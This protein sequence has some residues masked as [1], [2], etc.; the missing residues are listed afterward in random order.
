MPAIGGVALG[1]LVLCDRMFA[2]MTLDEF[3]L[4]A[5]PKVDGALNLDHVL[6]NDDSAPLDFFIGFSS[7]VATMGN[8]GQA[9]YAAANCFMKAIVNQRRA[10]GR[11][12]SIIDISRVV[13]VGFVEREMKA[14]GRL[15]REQKE[16]LFTGSMTLAMSEADLHQVFAEAI[17]A[18]TPGST[19]NSEIIT[20]IAPV[21]R[22]E[23]HPNSWSSNP[24]FGLLVRVG[25]EGIA[26]TNVPTGQ[27]PVKRLLEEA[28]SDEERS[29]T[30]NGKS[31]HNRLS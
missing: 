15:T 25:E 7:V 18:G 23:A 1:A 6:D 3:Q 17:V 9:N 11:S 19:A 27:I 5:R 28:Q 2:Q 31:C 4:V 12:G 29:K 26:D 14:D 20:G 8:P 16:R 13:G 30:L 21:R 24:K 22:D 10:R